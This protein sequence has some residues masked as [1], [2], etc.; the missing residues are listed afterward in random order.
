MLRLPSGP[1]GNGFLRRHGAGGGG[2]LNAGRLGFFHARF[3]GWRQ[4][5][6]VL[7]QAERFAKHS[8]SVF[9]FGLQSHEGYGD[10]AGARSRAR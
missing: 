4:Q 10:E 1:M 7:N 8:G 3:F 9:V 5:R 6:G 2:S